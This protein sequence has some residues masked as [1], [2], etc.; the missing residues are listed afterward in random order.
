MVSAASEITPRTRS[1]LVRDTPKAT[2][3]VPMPAPASAPRL[4]EPWNM[5]MTGRR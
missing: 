1:W 2:A 5:G 4:Q 3:A